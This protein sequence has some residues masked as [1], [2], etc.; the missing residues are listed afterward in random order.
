MTSP[1]VQVDLTAYFV[2]NYTG[3]QTAKRQWFNSA[4]S[5]TDDRWFSYAP[6]KFEHIKF[7][8]PKSAETYTFDSSWIYITAENDQDDTTTTRVWIPGQ[9]GLGL[10]WL[11]RNALGCPGSTAGELAAC[12]AQ[13]AFTPCQSGT[14]FYTSCVF[15]SSSG[16]NCALTGSTVTF[17]T[18]NYGYSIG[19]LPTIIKHDV[20]ATTSEDYYYGLGRGLLRYEEYSTSGTL[21]AWAAQTGELANQPIPS[22]VC[23]QP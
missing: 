21:L 20:F 15:T 6:N 16:A 5:S 3:W 8:D 18:Y 12:N 14:N 9:Y 23:F 4:G 13:N 19:S 2:P 1:C 7:S 22:N 17:T 11:P 10:R